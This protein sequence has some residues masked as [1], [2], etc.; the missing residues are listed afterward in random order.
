MYTS[1]TLLAVCLNLKSNRKLFEAFSWG[2]ELVLQFHIPITKAVVIGFASH[3]S[4]QP[5][6]I[7]TSMKIN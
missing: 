4:D 6:V 7:A 1:L 5:F 3:I 2:S